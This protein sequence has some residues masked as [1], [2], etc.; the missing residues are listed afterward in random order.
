MTAILLRRLRLGK[1]SCEGISAASTKGIKVVRHDKGIPDTDL[2]FRWGCTA[3][4]ET[5]NVVNTAKAI[6]LVS[7]KTS[8]RKILEE[9]KLC[10]PTWFTVQDALEANI[11]PLIVRPKTHAQGRNLH[12]CSTEDALESAVQHCGNDYYISQ[13][14]AKVAEYRVFVCQ[15]RAVWVAQKTPADPTAIAWNV[16]RGGR[17]DNVRWDSWP[18]KVVKTAIAANA[19]SGLDFGGVDVMVDDLGHCYVLEINSAPSQ[20]SPYRQSCVAKAFDYIIENG[21]EVLP[22]SSRPGGYRKF[23]HPSLLDTTT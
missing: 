22:L 21:K 18:L 6:H 17:F 7:D 8:F 5:N 13:Y 23:I 15:G 12:Y 19:L 9:H 1:T 14:I 2:V 3:T 16:A 10:P 11:W 4:V 20:T